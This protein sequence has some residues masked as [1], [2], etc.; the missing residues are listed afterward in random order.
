MYKTLENKYG[1]ILVS[2]ETATG[3][4]ELT[5]NGKEYT[6]L[7]NSQLFELAMT[8]LNCVEHKR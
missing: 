5:I 2:N 1:N 8:L 6:Q 4:V 7:T 3:L